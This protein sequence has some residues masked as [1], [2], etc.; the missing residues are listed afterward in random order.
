MNLALGILGI[1][2]IV[3]VR[4]WIINNAFKN[5]KIRFEV[6]LNI[7]VLSAILVAFL[8]FYKDILSLVGLE[9]LYI[10][11][12]N[13][14]KNIISFIIYCFSFVVLL[15]LSFGNI[16]KKKSIKFLLVS[17]LLFVGIGIGGSIMGINI[18]IMYYIISSYA[19]EFLKYSI[20]QNIYMEKE[21]KNNNVKIKNTDLIFFAII[22][23]LGFSVIENIFYLVVSYIGE[24]TGLVMTIGRSI[25]ATLLHVVATGLIAFFVVKNK[26]NFLKI[27]V[28]ILSGFGVHAAYNL[29]LYFEIKILTI[30]VL[31]VCY[32]ILSYLLFKSDLVYKKK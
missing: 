4:V 14:W 31:V 15:G 2:V 28:G 22:A 12:D 7:F 17:L 30:V 32:F 19:E 9:K 24:N 27:T 16:I 6:G 23:G 8:Y 21:K 29:S 3:Y 25:F 18:M 11:Q 10:L 5:K 13:N 26:R 20:G 1:I